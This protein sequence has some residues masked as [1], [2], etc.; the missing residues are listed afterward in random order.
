MGKVYIEQSKRKQSCK[1]QKP[2]TTHP[3][4]VFPEQPIR[5]RKVGHVTRVVDMWSTWSGFSVPNPSRQAPFLQANDLIFHTGGCAFCRTHLYFRWKAKNLPG[6]V[7]ACIGAYSPAGMR[8]HA[9]V[10][11]NKSISEWIKDDFLCLLKAEPIYEDLHLQKCH[12]AFIFSLSSKLLKYYIVSCLAS[13]FKELWRLY[14]S[15][16]SE[17]RD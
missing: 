10:W 5:P 13:P 6:P 3:K 8:E 4:K 1:E 14:V 15:L 2:T 16:M 17:F 7:Y 11:L 12:L 9:F